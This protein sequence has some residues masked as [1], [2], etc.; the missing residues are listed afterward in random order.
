[1]VAPELKLTKKERDPPIELWLKERRRLSPEDST[2]FLRTSKL[3]DTLEVVQAV[4][5]LHRMDERQSHKT[6]NAEKDSERSL[7]EL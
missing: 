4:R 7:R 1:M 3:P 2:F 5:H 6:T